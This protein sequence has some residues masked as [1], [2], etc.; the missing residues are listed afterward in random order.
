MD[1]LK[2]DWNLF[3]KYLP[4]WREKYLEQVNQHIIEIFTNDTLSNTEKFWKV[5]KIMDDKE[6]ILT[7]CFDN[8]SRSNMFIHIMMMCNDK[9]ITKEDLSEFSSNI[10]DQINKIEEIKTVK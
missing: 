10:T 4:T 9:V 5:K 6:K 1:S 7:D 2:S 8:Y 3:N